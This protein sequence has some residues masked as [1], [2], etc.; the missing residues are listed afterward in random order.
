MKSYSA[1]DEDIL[2][3]SRSKHDHLHISSVYAAPSLLPSPQAPSPDVYRGE[4]RDPETAGHLYA[5]E[6]KRM[7]EEAQRK[8]KKV[9]AGNRK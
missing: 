1:L 2:I 7:I 8:G 6:V 9:L 5:L 4:H 3:V